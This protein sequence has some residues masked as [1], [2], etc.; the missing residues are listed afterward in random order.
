MVITSRDSRNGKK[1][2]KIHKRFVQLQGGF[3]ETEFGQFLLKGRWNGHCRKINEV[4]KK[5]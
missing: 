5:K 4:T 1:L 2:V 3:M